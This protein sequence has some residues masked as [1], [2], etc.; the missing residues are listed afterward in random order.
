MQIRLLGIEIFSFSFKEPVI[1]ENCTFEGNKIFPPAPP[2]QVSISPE[3]R[4]QISI[5]ADISESHVDYII[6]TI[7]ENLVKGNNQQRGGI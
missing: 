4:K 3:L 2:T 7:N 6:Q 1:Y 5:E